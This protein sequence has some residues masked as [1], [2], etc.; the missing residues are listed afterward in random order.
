[1]THTVKKNA[2]AVPIPNTTD[3]LP[4][5]KST[6][7]KIASIPPGKENAESF[8]DKPAATAPHDSKTL[9]PKFLE[10]LMNERPNLATFLSVAYV[11]SITDQT[12][13]IRFAP[14]YGF[15]FAEITRKRNRD[16]IDSMLTCFAGKKYDLHITREK[17]QEPKVS[18]PEAPTVKVESITPSLQDDMQNEPII[19]T[20]LDVFDGEILS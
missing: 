18:E 13:D 16:T 12:I 14:Q 4:A 19:K 17:P 20:I 11:A 1:M 15:Q 8:Q 6:G 10:V 9:W 5:Q 7:A 2:P 3:A